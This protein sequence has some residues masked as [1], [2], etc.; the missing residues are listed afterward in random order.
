MGYAYLKTGR[1]SFV[2]DGVRKFL[3]KNPSLF[4]RRAR[5]A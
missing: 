2:A 4:R 1:Y 3:K 5:G